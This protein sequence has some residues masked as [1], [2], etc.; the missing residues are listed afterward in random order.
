[1]TSSLVFRNDIALL[2]LENENIQV[3][4]HFVTADALQADY[5]HK[6]MLEL[7]KQLLHAGMS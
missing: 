4:L 5:I 2:F 7:R 3:S 6:G 1:M